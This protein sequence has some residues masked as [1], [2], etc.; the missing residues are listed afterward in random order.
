MIPIPDTEIL[1]RLDTNEMV[2]RVRLTALLAAIEDALRRHRA[3]GPNAYLLVGAVRH[4]SL[5]IILGLGAIAI[6][7]VLQLPSFLV[8][9][10]QL[11]RDRRAEPNPFAVALADVMAFDGASRAD[12]VH[13]DKMVTIS[14]S[15]VPFVQ[16]IVF[17]HAIRTDRQQ[18]LRPEEL[19]P[20]EDEIQLDRAIEDEDQ[21]WV[22]T[23]EAGDHPPREA[24]ATPSGYVN[25]VT[26]IGQFERDRGVGS[27][28]DLRFV[29]QD[30]ILATSFVVT[31][32]AYDVEPD[33]YTDY[34]VTGNAAIE[35]D[36]TSTI[37]ILAIHPPQ[38][39]FLTLKS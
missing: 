10:K 1:F 5:E 32:N 29:P 24:R 6:P 19:L 4:G 11:A 3:G 16:K 38:N 37:E 20:V 15:E 18:A 14:K 30:P 34:E 39:N 9:L 17:G 12:F 2:E 23:L 21:D 28:T 31:T 27:V 33:E 35:A 22:P 25:S 26:M 8:D 13:K 7:A 36:G